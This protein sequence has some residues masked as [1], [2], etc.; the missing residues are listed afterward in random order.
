M[1]AKFAESAGFDEAKFA[2]PA[3]FSR[4]K[5]AGRA[6]FG[7]AKFAGPAWFNEA[8]F[9]WSVGFSEAEFAESVEF[10]LVR[11]RVDIDRA[12]SRSWP[13]GWVLSAEP[14]VT[15]PHTNGDWT[16][17]VRTASDSEDGPS[18]S[19]SKTNPSIRE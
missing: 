17:L 8:E 13:V 4:A 5:F 7:E 6:E 9:A 10:E 14:P 2:G 18:P 3:K 19:T 11:V 15:Y 16:Q 12:V 1:E